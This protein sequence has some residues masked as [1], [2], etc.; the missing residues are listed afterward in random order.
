MMK[1]QIVGGLCNKNVERSI[2]GEAEDVIGGVVL[3]PVHRLDAAVV[4]VAAPDDPGIRPMSP[5]AL[6]HVLDDGPHLDALGGARRAQDR[7]HRGR[8]EAP[9]STR[10]ITRRRM[11]AE[12]VVAIDPPPK[13]E[14]MTID[15]PIRW[16]GGIPPIRSRRNLL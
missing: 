9:L 11:S 3:R 15:S 7:H 14:S 6:S 4:T 13:V 10:P 8:R 2:A 5:Q 16:P 12:Y 1:A